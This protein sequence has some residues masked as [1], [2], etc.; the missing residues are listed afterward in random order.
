M[1]TSARGA[2]KVRVPVSSGSFC[3]SSVAG[4]IGISWAI[5]IGATLQGLLTINVKTGFAGPALPAADTFAGIQLLSLA[6]TVFIALLT[7]LLAAKTGRP[8]V[9]LRIVRLMYFAVLL[10]LASI[11]WFGDPAIRDRFDE[12][13]TSDNILRLSLLTSAGLGMVSAVLW[14][15]IEAR[16]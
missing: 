1:N 15:T 3:G 12:M 2:S 10:G 7:F 8:Q 13:T 14:R 9:A 5:G 11:S 6:G 16:R 4:A